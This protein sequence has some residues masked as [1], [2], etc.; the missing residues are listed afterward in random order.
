VIDALV[1]GVGV[2]GPLQELFPATPADAWAEYRERYPDLFSGDSWRLPIVCFLVR[3]GD[4]TVLFDTGAGPK[5]LWTDWDPEPGSQERLL[6]EL[7]RHE[8]EPEDV[9]IV[10]LSHVH[11]DHVGWNADRDG[12]PLFPRARY[13]LHED[14]LELAHEQSDRPHIQRCVLGIADRLES[15]TAGA[16]IA[17]GLTVVALPGHEVGHVGLRVRDEAVLIADASPH[18]AQLDHPEWTFAFDDDPQRAVETRQWLLGE[19][20]D[21]VIYSSHVPTGWQK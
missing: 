2:L 16:E 11:I 6:L 21:A 17:A 8:V 10:F 18:P 5:G 19:F 4:T 7:R 1:D 20:G 3:E 15:V 9:D 13:L 12:R 14:A